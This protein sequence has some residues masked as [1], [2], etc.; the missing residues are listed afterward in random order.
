M[1]CSFIFISFLKKNRVCQKL[2]IKFHFFRKLQEQQLSPYPIQLLFL[3]F[4]EIFNL[5]INFSNVSIFSRFQFFS[6]FQNISVF[7]EIRHQISVFQYFRKLVTISVQYFRKLVS[8][9]LFFSSSNCKFSFQ[10]TLKTIF[11]TVSSNTS[12]SLFSTDL[13]PITH[14]QN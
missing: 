9:V 2:K 8:P 11:A 13:N 7:K 12:S 4:Q 5:S 14:T 10:N 6:K 1:F 3:V